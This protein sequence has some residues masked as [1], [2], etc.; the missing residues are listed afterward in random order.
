MDFTTT[1]AQEELS[2]LAR[3]ILSDRVTADRLAE[4]EAAGLGFD[5]A[6]WA[7]LAGAGIL[8]AALPEAAGGDGYGLAEQC[9]ILV[10]CGRAIAP[11]PYLES[12]VLGA[13]TIARFGSAEQ[14]TRYAAPAAAGDLVIA[15]AL[16]EPGV[17]D[18]DSPVTKAEPAGAG[19]RLRGAKSVVPAGAAAGLFLVTASTPAGIGVFAVERSD[20]GVS[21]APQQVVAG[22]GAA[23]VSF[24]VDLPVGR[25]IGGADDLATGWLLDRAVTG[26]AALQLGVAE[27][28][29]ELTAEYARSRQAFGRAIG[30]FQAVAQRLADGYIDV[31]AM[32]LTMWQAAWRLENG[33]PAES[34]ITVAKFWA[35]DGGHR[36]AHTTVHVHGGVGIDVS[37]PVHRYFA[38][39]KRHEFALGGATA[40]LRHL[41]VLLAG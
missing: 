17:G 22:P 10:E 3:R 23:E 29:L 24:D 21:V 13:G 19:W 6:L 34:E 39:A 15:P 37:H 2:A 5:A 31:E 14:V 16:A 12:I 11:V 36:V 41:G 32:R 27:R 33:L 25:L 40:Q 9:S 7:D 8:A 18:P 4:L 20:D 35:A 38:A 26:L 1:Q 28:S 30:A